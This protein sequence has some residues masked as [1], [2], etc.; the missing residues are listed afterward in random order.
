MK[1][2]TGYLLAA[3][4]FWLIKNTWGNRERERGR[5]R[6][7]KHKKDRRKEKEEETI[8]AER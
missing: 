1:N 5:A 8:D 4:V 7:Q 6:Q 3:N 2:E